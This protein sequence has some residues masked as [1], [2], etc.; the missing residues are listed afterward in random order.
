[1][2]QETKKLGELD[3]FLCVL[4]AEILFLEQKD[5]SSSG[6][7]CHPVRSLEKE[8]FAAELRRTLRFFANSTEKTPH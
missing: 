1:M 4:A 8:R 2:S 5:G 6:D 7:T 3:A